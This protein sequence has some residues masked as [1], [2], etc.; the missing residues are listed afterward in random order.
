MEKN[1]F[2]QWMDQAVTMQAKMFEA[3]A[4]LAKASIKQATELSAEW[5]KKALALFSR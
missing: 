4:E 1:P 2:E 3:S 5:N